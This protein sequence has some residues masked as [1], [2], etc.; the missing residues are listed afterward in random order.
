M[1]SD[2]PHK[3]FIQPRLFGSDETSSGI[4]ELFPAIWN[5]AEDLSDPN[6][7]VRRLALECLENSGAARISPLITYLISSRLNDSDLE[8]RTRVVKILGDILAL[9]VHGNMAPEPVLSH[10]VY[11]LNNMRTRQVFALIEV[12]VHNPDLASQVV[13]LLSTC[14]FAGNHLI[15][16]ANSRKSPVDIRRQAIWLIGQ[17]GYLDAIP[18]LERLQIR[19]E[20]RLTGQQSMPFAPP[21]GF[22]ESELLPD[23]MTT[24]GLLRS[25]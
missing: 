9:D 21:L 20:T 4:A 6:T 1:A 11:Y 5:A 25:P 18:A 17:V 2:L 22:D 12:L 8:I 10:L 14:P 15:E 16:M 19:M 24:L 3:P 23:V 7:S 13:R